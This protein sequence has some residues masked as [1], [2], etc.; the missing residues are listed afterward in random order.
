MTLAEQTRMTV[1]EYLAWAAGQPG[2]YE[3]HEGGLT[4]AACSLT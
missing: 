3:L 4:I 1:D 2:R